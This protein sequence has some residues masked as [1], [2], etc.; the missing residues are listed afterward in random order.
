MRRRLRRRRPRRLRDPAGRADCDGDAVP[1][2]CQSFADCD[3]DG[4][5]DACEIA[6]GD[7]IDCNGNGIPDSCD[8]ADGEA[9]ADG[10]GIPDACQLEGP[11]FRF[12]V[13]DQWDGGFVAE[14]VV[15]N[16]DE[17]S[18]EG[19]TVAW[20]TPYTVSNTWNAV[21]QSTGESTEVINE[22]YNPVIPSGGSI[23]IGSVLASWS[24]RPRSR[25]R[26]ARQP[27]PDGRTQPMI[28]HRAIVPWDRSLGAFHRFGHSQPEGSRAARA[29]R[30]GLRSDQTVPV[31]VVR[32]WRVDRVPRLRTGIRD[33]PSTA[34]S[35]L[36]SPSHPPH[37]LEYSLPPRSSIAPQIPSDSSQML[38]PISIEPQTS[39]IA[40]QASGDASNRLDSTT[41]PQSIANPPAASPDSTGTRFRS[42]RRRRRRGGWPPNPATFSVTRAEDP[43]RP[44]SGA[45]APPE[46]G[47]NCR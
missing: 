27:E 10:D 12:V 17:D 29:G 26:N 31:E 36:R 20:D 25:Q 23:T 13:Q 8:L 40:S 42:P 47:T 44:D 33:R 18:I 24:N 35:R 11:T 38:P 1:D 37:G 15:L 3:G 46:P 39:S 34:P 41:A 4:A 28:T 32:S 7:E 19:W 22:V 43:R 14:L 30:R 21:L 5:P 45:I 9:D 6:A 2:D 16:G